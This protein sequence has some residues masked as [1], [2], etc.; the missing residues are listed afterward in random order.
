MADNIDEVVLMEQTA[1]GRDVLLFELGLVD[2][3]RGLIA[4]LKQGETLDDEG[5][6]D[7]NPR[8]QIR[9]AQGTLLA[10]GTLCATL[11]GKG[12]LD[13]Q[14]AE[15][16]VHRIK[17]TSAIWRKHNCPY[18]AL[19]SEMLA[20]RLEQMIIAKRDVDQ[21]ISASRGSVRSGRAQ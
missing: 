3:E 8:S 11:I 7:R 15:D 18:R 2:V 5:V 4:A 17:A 13:L 16:L 9:F 10:L 6:G 12:V 1:T 21:R 19:P 20:E 14:D